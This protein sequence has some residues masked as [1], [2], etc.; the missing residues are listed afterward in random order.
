[1]NP[2]IIPNPPEAEVSEAVLP[3]SI[4]ELTQALQIVL[5]QYLPFTPEDVS[6]FFG[7]AEVYRYCPSDDSVSWWGYYWGDPEAPSATV[8]P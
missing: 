4:E 1:M 7:G 5:Q 6:V 8:E 2:V 3:Q